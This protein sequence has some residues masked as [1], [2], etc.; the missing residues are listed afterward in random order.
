M[1]LEG[2]IEAL[3]KIL[4]HACCGPCS[5]E[6]VRLLQ[7]EGYELTIAYANSNIHP[8]SEYLHRRDTLRTWAEEAGIPVIEG[9]YDPDAWK[10]A[11]G[12]ADSW[13]PDHRERCRACYRLRLWEVARYAA[14]HGYDAISSTLTVSPYQFTD[15][16]ED[17]LHRAATAFGLKVVFRDF[18]PYYPEATRRSRELGM[19]RQNY[20]GCAFS[21]AEAAAEREERKQQRAQAKAAQ[22]AQR[23]EAEAVEEQERMRK[24]EQQAAR[25]AKKQAKRRARDAARARARAQGE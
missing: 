23:V 19:Y 12:P 7:E 10:E 22:R 3:T 5:L 25:D 21:D 9:V 6:P 20:C 15:V 16:I 8:E 4:L 2:S 11:I 17:E 13:G 1:Q 18:T 24:R 14:E